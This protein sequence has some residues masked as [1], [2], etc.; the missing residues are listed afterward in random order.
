MKLK[1]L[2]L[3]A[4]LFSANLFALE[5]QYRSNDASFDSFIQEVGLDLEV[6][7]IK[8][9]DQSLKDGVIDLKIFKGVRNCAVE[10][11][12]QKNNSHRLMYNKRTAVFSSTNS[13]CQQIIKKH[14]DD[15]MESIKWEF[16]DR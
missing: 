8:T 12:F 3:V 7:L 13:L 2:T 11:S 4:L 14:L 5:I 9:N 15:V 1:L 10:L 6:D 16:E